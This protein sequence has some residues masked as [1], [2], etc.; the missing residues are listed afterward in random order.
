M[1]NS[2]I[3]D[4]A[5]GIVFVYL[6]VSLIVS[7]ANELVAALFKMRGRNL[8]LGLNNLLPA[9]VAK[10]VYDHPLI[11]GL[12][13]S[14]RPSYIPSRTFALALLDVVCG[15]SGRI[16]QL[17]SLKAR[18]AQIK[19]PALQRPLYLLLDEAKGD[20]DRF[21]M[22]LEIWFN[23]AMA[24]VGG[25]Y[26]RKVQYALFFLGFVL[27]I[28]LNVDTI[29]LAN[30]LSHDSALRAAL[31]SNAE[32]A[33]KGPPPAASPAGATISEKET[34]LA[35]TISQLDKLSLPIGW[36]G[37]GENLT[38]PF[39]R[40]PFFAALWDVLQR[41]FVGWIITAFAATLG[42]PFWFDLLNRFVNIRSAG[43]APE[44]KPKDPKEV[45]QP[46]EPGQGK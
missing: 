14:N 24:R 44:E 19:D 30:Q 3:L 25:V 18:I 35:S 5:I 1:F 33:A 28:V 39:G 9:E 17:R 42:A 34:A 6:L 45:P 2:G 15:E 21:K 22:N 38:L 26:K 36:R 23:D 10:K 41:H 20:I 7:A 29:V 31:V 40:L 32:A 46:S 16:N 11:I 27:A 43:K 4:V 8:W 13:A 12:S 37:P